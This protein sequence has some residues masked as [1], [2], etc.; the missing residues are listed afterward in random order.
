MCLARR[1]RVMLLATTRLFDVHCDGRLR[2]L[3]Q[4]ITVEDTTAPELTIQP[5][6]SALTDSW[7]QRQRLTTAVR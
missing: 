1:L 3:T 5:T 6:W 4:T 7:M 2:L